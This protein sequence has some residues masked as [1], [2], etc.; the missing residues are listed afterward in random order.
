VTRKP[1]PTAA[2]AR[3]AQCARDYIAAVRRYNERDRD[4]LALVSEIERT[5][6]LLT[7][8]VVDRAV[9]DTEPL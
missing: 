4:D 1:R 3:V 8:A 2:D 9:E 7:A 5:M 6:D